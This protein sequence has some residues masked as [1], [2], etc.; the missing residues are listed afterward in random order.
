HADGREADDG[1]DFRRV[2]RALLRGGGEAGDEAGL[3]EGAHVLRAVF[4]VFGAAFEEDGLF[5]LVAATG[6]GPEVFEE[7]G[8]ATAFAPE[9]VV[10][11]DDRA[12]RV[13]DRFLDAGEPG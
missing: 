2:G 9:V 12:F 7:V 6:V 5:D 4:Q 10:W 3:A 1:A 8:E 11:V 13:D